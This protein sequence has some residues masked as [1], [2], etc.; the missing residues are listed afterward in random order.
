MRITPVSMDERPESAISDDE[1]GFDLPGLG[2]APVAAPVSAKASGYQV[3]ARKYR[4]SN[5]DDLVGQ[6]AMVRTL[7]NAFE[8]D[9]IAHAFMLT[10]VRGV[11]K[12][13]TARILARALNYDGPGATGPTI[14]MD[15]LGTHC[16]A[17]MES[18]HVD[19]LEMDA[20]SRTG[21][22]D[23]REI[24]D[25]VRYAPVSARYKVYIIDEVHMLSK[26]AFNGLLKTLEEPPAHVKFIFATTEIRKVPV[27]VLSRC[28]RFDLRR[29]TLDELV[30]LLSRISVKEDVPVEDAALKLIGRAAEGSARDSLSLLDRAIAHGA[31]MGGGGPIAE[32]DVRDMLGL[33]DR[34]RIFDLYD[35]IM[36]GDI[37]AALTE[38]RA[39]YDAGADPAVVLSDL[40]EL[41]H[42][43]MRLKLVA[44][45]AD[46]LAMS[47]TERNRG[48]EMAEKLPIRAL[49]RSWQVLLKGLEE[50]QAA[51]RP[52]AAAEMVLVRLA[53]LADMPGP[54]ELIA[55]LTNGGGAAGPANGGT[56]GGGGP[57][58]GPRARFGGGAAGLRAVANGG[59][60]QVETM[61]QAVAVA[62]PRLA[63]FDDVIA[64]AGAKRDV[65]LKNA[66]ET[67]VRLVSYEQ[68][69]IEIQLEAGVD[70]TLANDLSQKLKSWTGERW[71]VSIA[72]RQAEAAPTAREQAVSRAQGMKQEAAADPLVLAALAA[73][74]GAEIIEVRTGAPAGAPAILEGSDLEDM[75]GP[76]GDD[77]DAPFYED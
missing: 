25:S 55:S 34:A 5:F 67:G 26:A 60:A 15:G 20:A 53:Y 22:D 59:G 71:I 7:S 72:S 73:F 57:G 1:P 23:I 39:Q 61:P 8:R 21:I 66:L 58:G 24:I 35:F 16:A 9:R 48:R 70:G 54:E 31:L 76:V 14:H 75:P 65:R 50:V 2:P 10:G 68:G 56:M 19:V 27:T 32:T 69:R 12:T 52:I 30:G 51:P 3:L 40:A 29:L 36:K 33:A 4:P 17:I 6:E 46:D 45:A 41:T 49:S 38:L 13:T 64:L 37:A 44:A 62:G 47:E 18:R 43:L 42:W 11:G 63:T 77:F 28:Q 74:P